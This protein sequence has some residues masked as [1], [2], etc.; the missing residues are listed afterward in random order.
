VSV[1]HTI[2]RCLTDGPSHGYQLQ[3]ALRLLRSIYPLS[4]VNVYPVLRDLEKT[5][6]VQSSTEVID[7][8]ARRVYELTPAGMASLE[9]WLTSRPES[10]LAKVA[11]PLMLRLVLTLDSGGELDWLDE[12]IAE[13]GA[14]C[15][16]GANIVA[17]NSPKMNP[18]A[19]LAAEELVANLERRRAF[20]ERVRALFRERPAAE[21]EAIAAR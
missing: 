9:Q 14:E 3:R 12:A 18:V 2:L 4:N 15:A 11:D 13:L 16:D 5:G 1:E 6:F 17:A 19:K 20:L 7:S 10:W 21:V 8:R